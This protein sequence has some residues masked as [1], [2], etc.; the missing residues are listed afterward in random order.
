MWQ[1]IVALDRVLRGEATRMESLREGSIRIPVLGLSAVIIMLGMIAGLGVGCFAVFNHEVIEY[2]QTLATMVKVPLLFLLTLI[3]TFP[4]LY[5]FNALVGSRLSL[6]T[7]FRLL[8]AAMA[9]TMAV[10]ASFAPITAFFSLSTENY[11]FMVLLNVLLFAVAGGLGSLFLL[12]TLNRLSLID[13]WRRPPPP[14]PEP[15]AAPPDPSA[16]E[17]PVAPTA[18][19]A[20]G[21]RAEGNGPLDMLEGH[22]LGQHVRVVFRCWIVIFALVGGQMAWILR[23]FIG[24]PAIPFTWWRP[25]E[26]NFFESLAH[27]LQSLFSNPS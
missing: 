23:P 7:V 16:A 2:R 8:I 17:P 25:R 22:V 24:N 13:R 27:V 10:L 15:D 12:Q 21:H 14:R 19:P 11:S 3:V 20:P 1:W 18:T 9:V 4:S 26:S 5:V 6:V